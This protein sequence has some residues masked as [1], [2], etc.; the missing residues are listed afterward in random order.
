ML[1]N[2]RIAKN[3]MFLYFRMI[4]IM[5]VT[6]YT[7]RVI[8]DKL[9]VD[10][11]GLYNVVGGVVGLLSFLNGTF[12]I[13]TSRFLTY[14]LG[15]G[16][17]ER[18]KDT[19][20]TAFFVHLLLGLF[21]VLL[22]ETGGLW[23]LHNKLVIPDERLTACFW[24]FQLSILTALVS[25]T[26]VPYTAAI[27]AHEHMNIYAYISIFETFA[28]LGVCYML[29][30]SS[31]D[32]LIVY[33]ILIAI[34]QILVA[35]FYRV[36]C[37]HHFSESHLRRVFDR[38]IFKGMMGFSG[39]NVMANLAETLKL[40][41]YLVLLNMFFQPYVVTAQAIGNQVAGAMMQFVNNFRTAINPQIIKLYA[42]GNYEE[43]KRL[44]LN[45]TVLVFDLVL[46]L[47]LPTI[48]VMNTI[49][50][51]WLVEVPPYAVIFTQYIIVQ[52]ILSTFDAAFYIPMMA[53][54]KIKTNSIYATFSGPGLFM[55]LYII[56]RCGGDVMWMQYTGL[57]SLAFFGF[58]LKPY[59]LVQDE[60]GYAY[61]DFI[62]CFMTC[63]KV[64]LVS[65]GISYGVYLL[66]GNT[67]IV[68]SICLFVLSLLSV[69]LSSYMFMDKEM[70]MKVKQMII[71]SIR[72]RFN[73]NIK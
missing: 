12:S 4:L 26:Q 34:V 25:I 58:I 14:E 29:S 41:G 8:L 18:L 27:M 54:G 59:L 22:M 23:F 48:F 30:I 10:D 50:N 71:T 60:K 32:R 47:G 38:K 65:V 45:T 61:S 49:M 44:T 6:L 1:D 2:K 20:S 51:V 63:A 72:K 52:R 69:V 5:G 68:N 73:Q 37:V 40:Q 21:I 62:P 16:N 31:I 67:H 70:R 55:I 66:I 39:W 28:K 64:T 19:F 36:Y 46:L 17:Q 35:V 9:G 15:V 24:V 7:S 53:E 13:G 3:T 43:S 56:Y 42:A 57:F 11:Y 33:A